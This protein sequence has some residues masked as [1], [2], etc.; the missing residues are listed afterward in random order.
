MANKLIYVLN[1]Y[2][3]NSSEHYYHSINLCKELTEQ[4]VEITIL[5]EN[6]TDEHITNVEGIPFQ[7]LNS[8]K[9]ISKYIEL[10]RR[11]WKL[12][13]NGYSKVFVRVSQKAALVAL[14][15][16]FLKRL[17]VY[18]WQ[19]GTTHEIKKNGSLRVYLTSDLP[20]KIIKNRVY[21]FVTGPKSMLKYY[22]SKVGV[23][24]HKLI[25]LHND[26]DIL[27][28]SVSEIAKQNLRHT[29][30]IAEDVLVI[31]FVHRFS[32]VRKTLNYIPDAF[33]DLS[34]DKIKIVV[35]GGG[36]DLDKFISNTRE[37]ITKLDVLILGELPSREVDNWFKMADIFINP[38]YTE[39]FPR[40]LLEAMASKC[41]IVTTNAGGTK[42]ILS[43]AQHYFMVDRNQPKDF[44]SKLEHLIS[45][46][47]LIQ[48]LAESNYHWV[49]E[50]YS[51][52]MVA[53]MY[54]NV[55][56]GEKK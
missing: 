47:D 50:R 26:V 16:A 13:N 7:Y 20:F 6:Y 44:K 11:L 23:K 51:T 35:I 30:G 17:E 49:A 37:L 27:R 29:M 53:K 19:S 8:K 2:S 14:I 34:N 55:I 15:V 42:D 28:Y 54:K 46:P 48:D 5:V 32:P 52:P 25:E 33:K 18:Y 1:K 45:Q 21:R 36:P 56:F 22:E 3:V 38:S 31:L 39:G 4:G 9:R 40:V 10:G 43:Q 24:K 41:A 12:Q